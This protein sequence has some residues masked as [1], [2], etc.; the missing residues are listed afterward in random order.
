MSALATDGKATKILNMIVVI[1]SS[2]WHERGWVG[3]N[4]LPVETDFC[5]IPGAMIICVL[6][7]DQ[8]N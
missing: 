7:L 8:I 5:N 1:R 2:V 3:E 4:N 6:G